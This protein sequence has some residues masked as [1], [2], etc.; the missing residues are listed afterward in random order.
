VSSRDLVGRGARVDDGSLPETSTP[1]QRPL[2]PYPATGG[3]AGGRR[4][5][6]IQ[7][8][9]TALLLAV[10]GLTPLAAAALLTTAI[11]GSAIT[12]QVNARIAG[13]GKQAAGY[14]AQVISGRV[15][16][17]DA[18]ADEL[19]LLAV[20]EGSAGADPATAMTD[21]NALARSEAES[22]G[23][24][25][26]NAL[27]STVIQTGN[28]NPLT[29]LPAGW[30]STI[31]HGGFL[32]AAAP[33]PL[34]AP[35][36]DVA[37]PVLEGGGTAGAY[38]VEQYGLGNALP[39]LEAFAGDQGMRLLVLD[40][41]G[42]LILG[43]Q[44]AGRGGGA[45]MVPAW[46]AEAS[47]TSEADLAL[48]TRAVQLDDG[49][50][51]GPAA[52]S[53]MSQAPWVV[54]ASLPGSALAAVVNLRIAVFSICGAL[55]LLFLAA[56][57]L[58][59]RALRRQ[60]QT[61][62]SL[63]L[64]SAAMEHAAM[65]DPLTGLPNRLLFNDRLQ[66]GISNARRS[67]SPLAL[68]VL[69]IDGFKALNDALGHSAGDTV[70]KETAARLQASVRVSDTVARLGGD[71][72]VIVAVDANPAEAELI[73]VKVRQRMEEPVVIDERPVAVG[74]SI[75][76]ATYPED[77]TE[78]AHLLR[79]ADANMYHDKRVRESAPG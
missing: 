75:G 67:V 68:F 37:V 69:D 66:H 57:N 54:L 5:S 22:Q 40:R 1:P 25:L 51:G 64:Q 45:S 42:A 10:L 72:F 58:V 77:G 36:L 48:R 62:A 2:P 34:D 61:E 30:R 65:H 46:T 73:R 71:E 39:S 20:A 59:N 50:A 27:G 33:A 16:A 6:G 74:L 23:I 79:R 32:A 7:R 53:P 29:G 78:P 26:T 56:V 4:G 31:A 43:V 47:L 49:G 35:A 14:L 76:L 3:Q 13:A 38:L 19:P 44:P 17:L 63:I 52:F 21:L 11:A 70:L 8:R 55:A 24:V 15:T 60:E 12:D 9:R 41:T 28:Q 18:V